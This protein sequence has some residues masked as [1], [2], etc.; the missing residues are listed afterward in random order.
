MDDLKIIPKNIRYYSKF[1]RVY[2]KFEEASYKKLIK[3]LFLLK[4]IC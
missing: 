3:L 4:F 2:T 1:F